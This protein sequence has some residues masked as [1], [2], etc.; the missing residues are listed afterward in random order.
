[1]TFLLGQSTA[2]RSSQKSSS[3]P[4]VVLRNRAT[5]TTWSAFTTAKGSILGSESGP[6]ASPN[7]AK[8]RSWISVGVMF[9]R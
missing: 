4:A 6:T 3:R 7:R 9:P 8:S 5:S 1:M 2:V